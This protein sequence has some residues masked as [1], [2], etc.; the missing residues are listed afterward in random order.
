MCLHSATIH[1]QD[2]LWQAVQVRSRDPSAVLLYPSALSLG[3]DGD[4]HCEAARAGGMDNSGACSGMRG[5]TRR[6]F[7]SGGMSVTPIKTLTSG[8]AAAVRSATLSFLARVSMWNLS[9]CGFGS[10]KRS[11][12]AAALAWLRSKRSNAQRWGYV[13]STV[14]SRTWTWAVLPLA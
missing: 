8:L 12:S 10:A 1:L 3:S 11:K 4:G 2:A 5:R 6:S 9:V 13:K 14:P 7:L